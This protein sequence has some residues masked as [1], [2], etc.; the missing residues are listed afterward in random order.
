MNV[1]IIC[2]KA[3]LLRGKE[4]KLAGQFWMALCLL[5]YDNRNETQVLL[6]WLC[7]DEQMIKQKPQRHIKSCILPSLAS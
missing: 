4:T 7:V 1:T 5:I 2:S 6:H 3:N